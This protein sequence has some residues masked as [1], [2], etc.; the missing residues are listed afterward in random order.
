MS[1][2]G[3]GKV[4][5]RHLNKIHIKDRQ[6]ESTVL[7]FGGFL[8]LETDS[9]SIAHSSGWPRIHNVSQVGLGL[10]VTFLP[11]PLCWDYRH[12]PAHL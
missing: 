4:S 1:E 12:E 7:S 6:V 11:E 9:H 3:T 8:L 2:K 5:I 10:M